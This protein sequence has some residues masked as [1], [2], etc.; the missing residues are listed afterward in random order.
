VE[1]IFEDRCGFYSGV[2]R[3]F[4][5]EACSTRREY[6]FIMVGRLAMA[7]I[8]AAVIAIGATVAL[9]SHNLHLIRSLIPDHIIRYLRHSF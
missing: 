4:I 5:R 3:K 7:L 9:A 6:P 2:H 1:K 8:L